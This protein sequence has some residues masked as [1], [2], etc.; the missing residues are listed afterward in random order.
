VTPPQ[1]VL[2]IRE[3]GVASAGLN[4]QRGVD[5]VAARTRTD[6]I[7]RGFARVPTLVSLMH[8]HPVL[9]SAHRASR[10]A[11]RRGNT[12]FLDHV[13]PFRDF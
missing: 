2:R 9:A 5:L 4:G 13:A 3:A 11:L 12:R 1:S 10:R 8:E 7:D 6:P